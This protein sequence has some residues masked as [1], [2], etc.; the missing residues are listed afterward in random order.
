MICEKVLTFSNL[1][2]QYNIYEF[3]FVQI[4]WCSLY[5]VSGRHCKQTGFQQVPQT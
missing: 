1:S 3:P 5:S 2:D 4:T